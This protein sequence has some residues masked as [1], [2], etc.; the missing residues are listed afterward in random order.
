MLFDLRPKECRS[1]LFGREKELDELHRLVRSEWVI[2]LGRRMCGKTSLLKTFLR[3]VNGIYVN[4]MG[5]RSIR[6]FVVE[7]MKV[8]RTLRIEVNLGLAKISWMRLAE[9]IFSKLEGR[10]VGLDEVQELPPNYFLKLLKKL[11]DTYDIK[12]VM[13]GSMMGIISNLLEP[14]PSSP[15]YG[16]V[17]AILRLRPFTREQS[18]EFLRRGFAECGVAIHDWEIEEVVENLDGYP[19]W[20]TYYG[21]YRCVRGLTHSEALEEVYREGKL[22]MVDELKRFL[23]S[24][25]NYSKYLEILRNLPARWSDLEK[26]LSI[27]KKVLRDML[28]ALENAQLIGKVGATYTIPDPILRRAVLELQSP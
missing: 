15:M 9:D 19:G 8:V 14:K 6:G 28:R 17:P 26:K 27:N 1:E 3:E 22:V 2:I 5:V 23:R 10:I 16:R 25:R 18:I 11:W 21:N 20:L 7:L 24:R 4:L 12:L 13:T